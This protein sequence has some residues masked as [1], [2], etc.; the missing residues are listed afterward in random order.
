MCVLCAQSLSCV[1]LLCHPTDSCDSCSSPGSGVHG[2][3]QARILEW[4]AISSSRV[5]SW[6]RDRTP[7]SC[8]SHL[9]ADSLPL[10]HRGIGTCKKDHIFTSPFKI[11][12][13]SRENELKNFFLDFPGGSVVKNPANEGDMIWSLV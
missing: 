6:P 5:S 10:N 3:F 12:V 8:I 2:I 9:Q 11:V 1:W 4:V 13:R 7:I